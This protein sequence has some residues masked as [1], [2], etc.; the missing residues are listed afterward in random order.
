MVAPS[1]PLPRWIGLVNNRTEI[2][3]L[4][5]Q[6]SAGRMAEM[7]G[8]AEGGGTIMILAVDELTVTVVTRGMAEAL[9]A[10]VAVGRWSA[11]VVSRAGAMHRAAARRQPGAAPIVA[12]V[13]ATIRPRRTPVLTASGPWANHPRSCSACK[14][15]RGEA[16]TGVAGPEATWEEARLSIAPWVGARADWVHLAY[17]PTVERRAEAIA[18]DQVSPKVQR[19]PTMALLL[20]EATAIN[21][22]GRDASRPV[23][24]ATADSP[25][26]KDRAGAS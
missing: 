5:R 14:S 7:I 6:I 21:A 20:G 10:G 24:P 25:I 4:L 23:G 2:R 11:T 22:A 15:R 1:A 8:T 26:S 18:G 17:R 19:A 12:V 13:Q 3:A 9:L 16:E